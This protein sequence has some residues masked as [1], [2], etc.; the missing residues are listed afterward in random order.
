MISYKLTDNEKCVRKLL[1]NELT[2]EFLTTNNLE[3]LE[4]LEAGN[5]PLPAY[6][7]EELQ[8]RNKQMRIAELRKLLTDSDF[9][10]TT[11]YYK[12]MT[13]EDQIYWDTTRESWRS[14]LRELLGE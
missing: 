14:E 10:M 11:D 1:N 4:W 13:V 8:E 9:R 3:Y 7:E 12:R 2:N 5:T 6:T